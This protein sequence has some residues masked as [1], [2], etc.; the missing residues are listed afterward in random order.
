MEVKF[1]KSAIK[2]VNNITNYMKNIL[3]SNQASV[4]F[5]DELENIVNLLGFTDYGRKVKYRR[6]QYKIVKVNNYILFYTV[7]DNTIIIQKLIHKSQNRG[8]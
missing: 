2:D 5:L 6:K 4:N 3:R 1:T 7:E 8:L